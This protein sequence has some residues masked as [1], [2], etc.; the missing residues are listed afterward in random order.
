MQGEEE[1]PGKQETVW[2]MDGHG[3]GVRQA[4]ACHPLPCNVSLSRLGNLSEP[5]L[6][7]TAPMSL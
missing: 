5:H 6:L 7:I 2:P 4:W 1:I 3:L